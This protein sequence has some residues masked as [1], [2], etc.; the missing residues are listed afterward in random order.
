[1][2]RLDLIMKTALITGI[3]GQDGSY[4]A[5]LLLSKG[6][7]VHG[8][9]RRISQPNLSNLK[10]VL[11]SVTLHTAD[12]QDGGSLF[13][14]IKET[15]PDEIYNFAAM[16]QVRDSYDHPDT[17]H[18]IN[19]NGLLRVMEAVRVLNLD[20]KIYQACS[21]EM[22]GKVK[23]TPQ[24][25]TTPFHPRSPYG[26]SKVAAYNLARTWREAYGMKIYCGILFNHE[27]PRRGE[28][29]LSRKVCKAVAEIKAGKRD[30]L[31]LGNLDAKRDWGYAKE[32][33]EWIWKIVQYPTAEDFVIATGETHSVKEWV[34]AAFQYVGITDWEKY[35]DYD[36]DLTRPA[37]VDLLLGDASKSKALL[38]FE[39]KVKFQ[40]LVAIMTEAE[41]KKLNPSHSDERRNL[42]SF[43]EAKLIEVKED[44]V[45]GRHYHKIKEE[46]FMLSKGEGRIV[47]GDASEPMSIGH[48]YTVPPGT[49]HEFHLTKGS[50]LIGLN[51]HPYDPTDDYRLEAANAKAS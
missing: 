41:L 28:A 2:P 13:R 35:V 36:K 1:M 9:V 47:R 39:P 8:T 20:C 31:I 25:E 11:D 32:Y 49:Y 16:S 10:D 34:E 18:D 26:C 38:G 12:M 44:T 42:Y 40:E 43:P 48:I 33:V 23:E 50:I 46:R 51:S 15:M 29:F 19:V 22:F 6:Y 27:S 7:S 45:I 21:S 14:V 24:T 30:K 17:T 37:E 5:E 4:L 3:T